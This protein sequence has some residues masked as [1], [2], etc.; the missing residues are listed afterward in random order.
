[1]LTIPR[2]IPLTLLSGALTI[3]LLGCQPSQPESDTEADSSHHQSGEDPAEHDA[4]EH[5][6][7]EHEHTDDDH[8]GEDPAEHDA[9][10]HSEHEHS[11]EH[12]EHEHAHNHNNTILN[13]EPNK[14]ISVFY[15]KDVSP[16][17]A[18]LLI[19]GIEYDLTASATEQSNNGEIYI[20]DIG[21][22]DTHGLIWQVNEDSATLFTSTT[23]IGSLAN[24]ALDK[25]QPLYQCPHPQEAS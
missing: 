9:H 25:Q 24:I 12:S 21:L 17:T 20:S 16:H 3:S 4:H 23:P 18:H 19:D 14:E 11:D 22:D 5:S 10:E 13:C 15:H 1:M 2:L 8:S 6:E 7:H